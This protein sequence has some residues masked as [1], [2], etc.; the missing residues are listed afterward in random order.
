MHTASEQI[1]G[2]VIASLVPELR[3]ELIETVRSTRNS[4][5]TSEQGHSDMRG[6][7]KGSDQSDSVIV[8]NNEAL[9]TNAEPMAINSVYDKLGV[10][11]TKQL[12]EKIINGEYIDLGFLLEK[13]STEQANM[14]EVN[15]SGQLVV[16]QKV[17]KIIT[18]ISSW[19]DAFLIFTSIYI[20]AHPNSSQGLLKY[21]HDV[22]LGASRSTGLGWR[23]YDQQFR[24][25]KAR[26]PSTSWGQVDQEL[27]LIYMNNMVLPSNS[28]H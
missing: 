2:N 22:K 10:H 6:I 21:M 17:G 4:D 13:S 19:I 28:S 24:L 26:L 3:G 11:V 1:V 18:D 15:A 8:I 27:W 16:K 7:N 12:R 14:L 20:Y 5:A 25:K 9:S 23:E